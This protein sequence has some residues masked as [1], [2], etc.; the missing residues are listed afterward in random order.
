MPPPPL[1]KEITWRYLKRHALQDVAKPDE[2]ETD[3]GGRHE[4]HW[5]SGRRSAW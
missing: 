1:S 3:G 5:T 2:H 4:Y